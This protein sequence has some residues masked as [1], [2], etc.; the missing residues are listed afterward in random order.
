MPIGE[1][2]E[3]EPYEFEFFQAVRLLERLLPEREPVG[4]FVNPSAE[5]ARF[6]VNPSPAFPASQIQSLEIAKNGTPR[7]SVNFMGLI[8]PLG[9][10]PLYYTEL[11]LERIRA[12]DNT[13]RDFL[14]VFHHRMISLF[15][16]AW[17]KYRFNIAYER[18]ERDRFSHHLLD[19]LGVGTPGLEDRQ[20]VPDD[21]LLFYG[22]LLA[23]HARSA[24]ALEQIL[25]D[26]FDVPVEV[27]QFVGAWYPMDSDSQCELG[28][29][30]DYSAQ[31]GFGA[32]VGNE[33]WDQQ[34][35]ARIRLGPLTLAQYRDFLP[36]GAA[37]RQLRA[38]TKFF[39]GNEYDMEVQLILRRDEVPACDLAAGEGD[40]LQLGWT[41][42]VKSAPFRRDPGDTILSL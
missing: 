41:T 29:G 39:A 6:G 33:I 26:Y 13:L 12:R 22:G 19:L 32:V 37:H 24:T 21:S 7:L 9:L 1:W 31:L 38:L 27:E 35:R 42:W 3:R 18:G 2:L 17:E 16:A 36:G 20:D 25:G 40:G 28:A 5:V 34:S 23:L 8:G 10:L 14:D 30:E 11:V 4:R 15:F